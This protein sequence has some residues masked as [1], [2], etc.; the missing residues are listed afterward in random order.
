MNA[1]AKVSPSQ[2]YQKKT[3]PFVLVSENDSEVLDRR[4]VSQKYQT[5]NCRK[6]AN[7]DLMFPLQQFPISICRIMFDANN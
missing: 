5:E 7:S 1:L 3:K 2:F 6:T 4:V